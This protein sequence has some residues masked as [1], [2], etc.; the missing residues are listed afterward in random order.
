MSSLEN[1]HFQVKSDSSSLEQLSLAKPGL[2][3]EIRIAKAIILPSHGTEDSFYSGTLDLLDYLNEN[4]LNTTIYASDDEY[5]ELSLHGADH[6]IGKLFINAVTIPLFVGLLTNY[7]YGELQA[8]PDDNISINVVIEKDNGNSISVDF[9][10]KVDDL[11]V[12]F[13]EID[14]LSADKR[15]EQDANET[16]NE[17]K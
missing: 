10:G 15:D 5:I 14:K 12:A 9:R 4:G 16:V 8:K 17:K 3:E 11:T 1:Y 6:W 2:S 7:V 13:N